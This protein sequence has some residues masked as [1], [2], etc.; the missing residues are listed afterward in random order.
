[1]L[2]VLGQLRRLKHLSFYGLCSLPPYAAEL[3]CHLPYLRRLNLDPRSNPEQLQAEL[4]GLY[5]L[6]ASQNPYY[7]ALLADLL[8]GAALTLRHIKLP[9]TSQLSTELRGQLAHCTGL[10]SLSV[11]LEDLSVVSGM[12][13][14]HS[15]DLQ[16]SP[17]FEALE[18]IQQFLCCSSL[19]LNALRWLRINVAPQPVP[20]RTQK[21][22]EVLVGL[23]RATSGVR[24]LVLRELSAECAEHLVA[25]LPHLQVVFLNRCKPA[26][27]PCLADLNNLRVLRVVIS[28]PSGERW[29][30]RRAIDAFRARRPDIKVMFAVVYN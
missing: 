11:R 9:D 13:W 8:R 17:T 6:G 3:N 23:A 2:G 28:C 30:C 26:L 5:H 19:S 4:T 22:I 14:L 29:N 24:H 27:L 1:L 12:S 18:C 20:Q 15:L 10:R 16:V 25:L 7:E 21:I